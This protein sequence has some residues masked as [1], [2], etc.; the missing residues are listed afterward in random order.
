LGVQL[1]PNQP[2]PVSFIESLQHRVQELELQLSKA[3]KS[4]ISTV[5]ARPGTS[6]EYHPSSEEE[7]GEQAVTARQVVSQEETTARVMDSLPLSFMVELRDRQHIS[8]GRYSFETF[9]NAATSASGGHVTRSDASS[10]PLC[11]KIED[12]HRDVIPSGFK[13]SRSTS[14]LPVQCYLAMCDV[15][16]PFLDREPFLAKYASISEEMMK[17][18][19]Q[20]LDM[21]APHDL[22][23]V[24]ISLATGTLLTSEYRF[25]ESFAVALANEALR[26]LPQ[27]MRESDDPFVVQSLLALA[28]FSIHSPLGGSPWHL[29]GLALAR[30]TSAGMSQKS[31]CPV[32]AI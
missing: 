29:V 18:T 12:F 2:G 26:L 27:I 23:L 22:F 30:S 9:L 13:L 3:Q 4:P 1:D 14:D 20:G 11:R 10:T 31:E 6:H 15:M 25:K 19:P 7:Q 32:R 24:Y 17:G 8:R 5:E 28:L 16:C 21:E